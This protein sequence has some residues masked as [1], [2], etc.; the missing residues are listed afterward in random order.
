MQSEADR[1]NH[2]SDPGFNPNE[3]FKN[4]C[5]DE[6][7]QLISLFSLCGENNCICLYIIYLYSPTGRFKKLPYYRVRNTCFLN[8]NHRFSD[9]IYMYIYI[10]IYIYLHG[11]LSYFGRGTLDRRGRPSSLPRRRPAAA[12]DDD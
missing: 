4:K 11:W 10:Y 1:P 7:E 3:H 6:R 12:S 2:T 9:D 8:F 5:M